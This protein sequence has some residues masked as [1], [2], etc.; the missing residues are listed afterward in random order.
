LKGKIMA[1]EKRSLGRHVT[2]GKM[3]ERLQR[4]PAEIEQAIEALGISPVLELNGLRYYD[5]GD[6]T[7][8][9]RRFR[10]QDGR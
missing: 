8:I 3:S 2:V 10:E 5:V 4:S 7:A 6:E 1:I 9:A